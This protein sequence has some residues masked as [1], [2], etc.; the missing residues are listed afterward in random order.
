MEN[1]DLYMNVFALIIYVMCLT[2]L[3][4]SRKGRIDNS[5]KIICILYPL[6]IIAQ[7]YWRLKDFNINHVIESFIIVFHDLLVL[8]PSYFVFEMESIRCVTKAKSLEHF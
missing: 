1:V 4:I 2:V 7:M 3:M 5:A 6:G 8:S